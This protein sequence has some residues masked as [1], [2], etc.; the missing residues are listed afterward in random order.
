MTPQLAA[1]PTLSATWLSELGRPDSLILLQVMLSRVEHSL[2][3]YAIQL[4]SQIASF[5][6]YG[7]DPKE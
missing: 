6:L 2:G 1:V 7:L 4:L 5:T 3:V